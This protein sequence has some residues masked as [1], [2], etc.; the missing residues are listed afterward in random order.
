MIIA[1]DPESTTQKMIDIEEA[2]AEIAKR[3]LTLDKPLNP[4]KCYNEVRNSSTVNKGE[5]FKVEDITSTELQTIDSMEKVKQVQEELLR[6][7][8]QNV[9]D[10]TGDFSFLLKWHEETEEEKNKKFTKFFCHELNLFIYYKDPDYFKKVVGPF[11]NNKMEKTFIDNWLL[12]NY[13][14]IKH[15]ANVENFEKLNAF[16]K[17]LLIEMT[18]RN[19]DKVTAKDLADKLVLDNDASPINVTGKNKIFDTVLNLNML[20]T[21]NEIDALREV[22][23]DAEMAFNESEEMLSMER[24]LYTDNR[25][26]SRACQ[27]NFVERSAPQS[28]L[29][30]KSAAP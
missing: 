26:M 4:E 9:P 23:V 19:G 3:D 29:L 27:R 7:S 14:S 2:Q 16:E 5:L 1:A 8:G 11:I 25:G 24:E 30:C 10:Y 13:L 22:A 21:E 17:C 28:R 20:S 15:F 6:L 18:A 12:D